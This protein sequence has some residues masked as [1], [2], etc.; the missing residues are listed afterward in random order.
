MLTSFCPVICTSRPVES[1][2]FYRRLFG[3]T[4]THTTE[5]YAGLG[6]PGRHQELALVDHGHPAL[7]EAYRTPVRAVRITLA[8][9]D[10]AGEWE[11]LAAL[12]ARKC[13]ERGHLVV[14]DPNGVWI[15][16]VAPN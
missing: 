4:A 16:V 1:R 8:V 2:T 10:R 9:D 7:P 11:R 3:F 15:D 14:K 12:G 13:P 6:R 5:W